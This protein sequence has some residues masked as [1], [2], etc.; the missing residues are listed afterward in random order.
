[1]KKM[2]IVTMA[3]VAAFAAAAMPTEAEFAK[4]SEEVQAA[5]KAQIAAW[6]KGE[7]SDG[8]LAG[9]MLLNADKFKD[10]ARHYAC[11]Q[12][13][14]AAA[15]RSGDAALAANA[16][17]K[18][19]ADTKDFGK[20][21]ERKLVK[22]AFE[23]VDAEKLKDFPRALEVER[24]KIMHTTPVSHVTVATIVKMKMIRVPTL[25]LKPPMTLADAVA[26]L[27]RAGKEYDP[28]K[29][30]VKI[31]LKTVE[32]ESVPAVPRVRTNSIS[33]YDAVQL[34]TR[35]SGYDFEVKGD[36]AIVFKKGGAEK[37]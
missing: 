17:E 25:I 27:N 33:L 8:D 4:A 16:I 24:A 22:K 15:V 23:K 32:G 19:A 26:L 30:G 2:A 7:M 13:A 21:E 20:E 31:V 1:M 9:L 37:K 18:I 29:E 28:W 3:A 35:C 5:L 12:A 14:F 10:E 36:S 6:Q 34:V 11:L